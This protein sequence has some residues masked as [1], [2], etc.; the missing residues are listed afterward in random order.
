TK[1]FQRGHLVGIVIGSLLGV[2]LLGGT[3]SWLLVKV[4]VRPVLAVSSCYGVLVALSLLGL[5]K[6][7]LRL[8]TELQAGTYVLTSA[9]VFRPLTRW[10][11]T[12]M[13]GADATASSKAM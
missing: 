1:A 7:G 13:R 2:L 12:R 3:F 6:S 4:G 9:L 10:L 5:V 11:A 8:D